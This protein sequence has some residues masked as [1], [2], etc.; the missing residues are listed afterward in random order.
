MSDV[1][2]G[3][4]ECAS[5][6][7]GEEDD[8][9]LGWNFDNDIS[10][11]WGTYDATQNEE[12]L[13]ASDQQGSGCL[14]FAHQGHD[15]SPKKTSTRTPAV[16]SIL[17]PQVRSTIPTKRKTIWRWVEDGAAAGNIAEEFQS[18][19]Q[20]HADMDRSWVD[21]LP[22]M[23]RVSVLEQSAAPVDTA[24]SAAAG[25][26]QPS[27]GDRSGGQ[28]RDDTLPNGPPASGTAEQPE[29]SKKKA[30]HCE[31]RIG[32]VPTLAEGSKMG[33][34]M[35]AKTVEDLEQLM[36]SHQHR[37]GTCCVL[38][39]GDRVRGKGLDQ[40]TTSAKWLCKLDVMQFAQSLHSAESGR[41][42]SLCQQ[43]M[44]G[45]DAFANFMQFLQ[46]NP[47]TT[48]GFIFQA[49]LITAEQRKKF[50]YRDTQ[51]A[52]EVTAWLTSNSDRVE[53]HSSHKHRLM[54][55]AAGG[56][57]FVD[58]WPYDGYSGDL[59]SDDKRAFVTMYAPHRCF[60]P[61]PD[62]VDDS[63]GDFASVSESAGHSLSSATA[64]QEH[65]KRKTNCGAGARSIAHTMQLKE[66]SNLM[67]STS[68]PV[69]VDKL[70]LYGHSKPGV[71]KQVRRYLVG[72]GP[73]DEF[74]LNNLLQGAIA[75]ARDDG[76]YAELIEATAQEVRDR[77]YEIAEARYKNQWKRACNGRKA[78]MPPFIPSPGDM[79]D[80]R[81]VDENG[82]HD[83]ISPW[84]VSS[85][86][87]C[88][89]GYWEWRVLQ[90]HGHRLRVR[91]A[92]RPRYIL[93]R[94]HLGW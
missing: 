28:T 93:P 39:G 27:G 64:L 48:C 92:S 80:V 37:Q 85:A 45:K 54:T 11:F 63:G 35:M 23:R 88:P 60:H 83:I 29:S 46:R 2:G 13:A 62:V 30:R 16:S 42:E 25:S 71:A 81:D 8:D 79:P 49:Q 12:V 59:G 90:I 31:H 74:A 75:Q 61:Q 65:M 87:L 94:G 22:F 69:L 66:P 3:V 67:Q 56:P 47:T 43:A 24:S 57:P 68:V 40:R 44:R 70:A 26:N 20:L 9:S 19:S 58:Q 53:G 32:H 4:P 33:F 7:S 89:E 1:D 14:A 18:I 73:V 15:E 10:E 34:M 41:A 76:D 91:E 82:S 86:R 84:L 21:I 51:A 55:L 72:G 38:W 52:K 78:K 5:S 6:D 50:S 77:M 17:S 36:R